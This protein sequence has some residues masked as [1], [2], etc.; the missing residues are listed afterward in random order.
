MLPCISPFADFPLTIL[1]LLL[2]LCVIM[3]SVEGGI[4]GMT[5]SLFHISPEKF[6]YLIHV[7]IV[8]AQCFCIV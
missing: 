8:C 3:Q 7:H 4:K 2:L 1:M 5:I 6:L